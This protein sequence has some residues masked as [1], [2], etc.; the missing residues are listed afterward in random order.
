MFVERFNAITDMLS[1]TTLLFL[2]EVS[3]VK[4]IHYGFF[5]SAEI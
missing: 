5:A 4:G 2:G 3:S 1:T